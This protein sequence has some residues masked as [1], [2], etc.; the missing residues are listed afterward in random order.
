MAMAAVLKQFD[1]GVSLNKKD[2]NGNFKPIVI[3]TTVIPRQGLL[4]PE[5]T[6][7]SQDCL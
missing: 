4:K 3:N 1:A 5:K 2:T 6:V 7:Y